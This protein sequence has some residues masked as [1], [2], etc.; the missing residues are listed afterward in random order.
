MDITLA[1]G[2]GG[3]RGNAHVGVIRCL[4]EE[5]YHVR[6]VAGTS[7]GGIV[8]GVYAAGYTPDQM[9]S[10]FAKVDQSKLFWR[11]SHEG[12]SLLGLSGA[13]KVLEDLLGER[14]FA[15]L[16]IPCAMVAV[17]AKTGREVILDDGR[18]VDAIMATIAIP[19]VF[20]PQERGEY[21]LVDGGVLNPVPV[22][23]ARALAPSLPVV[24]VV[25]STKIEAAENPI[26]IPLPVKIPGTIIRRLTRT[27]LA[28]AFN[29]YLLSVEASS[30]MLTEL[31]LK[32]D[33]PE[34]I[35]RPKVGN[36]GVLDKVD[37]HK[38]VRLGEKAAEAVLPDLK[39]SVSWSRRVHRQLFPRK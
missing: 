24:A 20:P 4:E 23:A 34:I 5:G 6:G 3:A 32:V 1:L 27:R 10:L 9:E 28:Q 31:R 14:R 2:G 35:I 17:D 30:R 19:G 22:S 7:A 8:A 36:I 21:Q 29:I 39:R 12:P 11:S 26:S 37:V 16:K 15:D 33:D 25:L 13:A 38:I 18:V